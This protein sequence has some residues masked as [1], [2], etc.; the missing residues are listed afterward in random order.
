M[1]FRINTNTNSAFTGYQLNKSQESLAGSLER[2][3]TGKRINKAS[4][5]ASGM[6]IA[7]ALA[8]QAKG[9]G[10]AI[11][12]SNDAISMVQIADGALGQAT[13]LLQGIREKAIQA[14]SG[15]QSQESLQ[16]IQNE[17]NSSLG[18]LKDIAQ[19]TSFNGQ[20][21]LSGAFTGKE[22]QVGASSGETIEISLSSIDPS[23][24]SDETLGSLSQIDVTTYEGA[25][26]AIE[27]TDVALDYVSQQRSEVGSKHN[28][29]ETTI[30]NLQNA[31]INTFSAQ[32]EIM[33]L[34]F[35]EESSNLNRIKLLAKA[36]SFA[37]AQANSS[38]KNVLDLLG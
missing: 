32:S 1:S 28:Q 20:K 10:Q 29:L 5:D 23:Q 8:S 16:A 9:Y 18:T 7:N 15:I 13:D 14:S 21:I 25:Q 38:A 17:I 12:N 35:A 31:R 37:Y 6:V 24:I 11:K 36:K 26:A 33:D 3:S 4:D 2:L 22:F 27:L 34:D 30:S 19:N